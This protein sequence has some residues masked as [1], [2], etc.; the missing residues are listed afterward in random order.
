MKWIGLTIAIIVGVT[1][2]N[3]T[4]SYIQ[5]KI[6]THVAEKELRKVNAHIEMENKKAAE[7]RRAQRQQ[8]EERRQKQQRE[9]ERNADVQR[10]LRSTCQFW[11]AEYRKTRNERDMMHRNE[12]CKNAGMPVR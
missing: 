1:L 11:I 4:S 6:V 8:A 12:A 5:W 7:R 2:G 3:L 9:R 10:Q